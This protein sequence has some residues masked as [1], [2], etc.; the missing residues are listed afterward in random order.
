MWTLLIIATH[1]GTFDP[2]QVVNIPSLPT[3]AACR[4]MGQDLK[5]KYAATWYVKVT[6][7]PQPN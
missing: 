2:P 3:E 6:C 5:R 4:D 7:S 1:T